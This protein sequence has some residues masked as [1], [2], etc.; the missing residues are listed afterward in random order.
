MALVVVGFLL[1]SLLIGGQELIN[2]PMLN[3]SPW[4]RL[5]NEPKNSHNQGI[6]ARAFSQNIQNIRVSSD[7][8]SFDGFHFPIK[9]RD[10][11][12]YI[13]LIA[14]FVWSLI[15]LFCFRLRVNGEYILYCCVANFIKFYRCCGKS[16]WIC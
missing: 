3:F 12:F 8:M 5:Q 9:D 7:I 4:D 10:T 15:K 16:C 11:C 13:T 6:Q 14:D 1:V 2:E